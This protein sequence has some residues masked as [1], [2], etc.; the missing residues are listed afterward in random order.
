MRLFATQPKKPRS[1]LRRLAFVFAL[2]LVVASGAWA[3]WTTFGSGSGSASSTTAQEVTISAGSPTSQLYPNG[4]A[5][6]ALTISNPNGFEVSVPSLALDTN[7]G[8]NGF[9]VD[10]THAGCDVSSLS[11]NPQSNSGSGWQVPPKAGTTDG[12]LDLDLD[13]AVSMTGSAA[14]ACQGATFTVYL[15]AG[16]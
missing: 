7:Q 1:R 6:L 4:S 2:A 8:T 12:S 15:K 10:S 9:D 11:F 5:D 14:N 3:Y 13:G 16:S